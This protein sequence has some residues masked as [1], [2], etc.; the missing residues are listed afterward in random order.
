[1]PIHELEIENFKGIANRIT[2]PIRPITLF[3]GANSSGKSTCIHGLTALAQTV[4]VSNDPRPLVLDDDL[5]QVHLGRFIEVSHS[6]KYSESVTLGVGIGET[7][8]PQPHRPRT[9]KLDLSGI[10]RARYEFKC[11]RR[12]QDVMLESA[13]LSIGSQE[14]SAKK[15]GQRYDLT[16]KPSNSKATFIRNSG[17]TLEWDP[18]SAAIKPDAI[19]E[20]FPFRTLQ[21]M[22]TEVL[23]STLYLGPFRQAPQRRYPTR[24]SSPTEVGAQGEATVTLLAN[25]IV[26]SRNRAHVKQIASWLQLLGLGQKLGLSRVGTSDL[27]DVDITLSDGV[28]LPIADLGYGLSQVLP[29]L[30]QCSFAPRGSTLLFEQPELHLHQLA[31]KQLAKVFIETARDR[32]SHIVAETH[33]PDLMHQ[34]LQEMRSG[35]LNAD[36][37][38]FYCVRRVDGAT[39]VE[40]LEVDPQD[41]D[42][43]GNWM[44][45]LTTPTSAN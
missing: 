24:G 29:V 20:T 14:Y 19:Y 27:F 2:I 26:Q 15:R 43:Y 21:R 35:R 28:I 38:V 10:A 42:V 16:I 1:M 11:T 17:F 25:E 44:T 22:V 3:I 7:T 37:A 33:S 18:T 40:R 12:T 23:R 45:G 8:V 31:A 30:A 9:E 6:K 41:F 34:V 4:K 39:N 13:M 32:R 5:A 36:D